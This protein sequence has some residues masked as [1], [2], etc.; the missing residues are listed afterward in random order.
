MPLMTRSHWSYLGRLHPGTRSFTPKARLRTKNQ[1]CWVLSHFSLGMQLNLTFWLWHLFFFVLV[2]SS[3]VSLVW[4]SGVVAPQFQHP[5]DH[6]AGWVRS[7][8]RSRCFGWSKSRDDGWRGTCSSFWVCCQSRRGNGTARCSSE[9]SSGDTRKCTSKETHI[10]AQ[11][12]HHLV[13]EDAAGDEDRYSRHL[14]WFIT[15]F[16]ECWCCNQK[17]LLTLKVFQS[18]S[19]LTYLLLRS[20]YITPTVPC[21]KPLGIIAA[22][23]FRPTDPA[24]TWLSAS[25]STGCV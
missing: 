6:D 23:I 19:D 17:A 25:W 1:A 11:R 8:R 5:E 10:N 4:S 9:K 18:N 7:F 15:T 20:P 3:R 24:K 16:L 21:A 14:D 13:W 12:E 22:K 2:E